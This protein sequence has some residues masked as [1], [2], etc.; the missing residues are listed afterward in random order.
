MEFDHSKISTGNPPGARG[1]DSDPVG[2]VFSM[3]ISEQ[4]KGLGRAVFPVL[5]LHQ[6]LV[7]RFH[8]IPAICPMVG[9]LGPTT[10]ESFYT[11]GISIPARKNISIDHSQNNA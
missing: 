6:H 8:R 3:G 9:C 4:S 7:V 10:T 1:K 11:P 2:M 5:Y